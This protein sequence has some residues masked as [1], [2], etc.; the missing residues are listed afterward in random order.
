MNCIVSHHKTLK[1]MLI[2]CVIIDQCT[3]L[4]DKLITTN[5]LRLVKKNCI[6]NA[7]QCRK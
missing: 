6:Q 7:Y 3:L 2:L 5:K 1:C 4:Q